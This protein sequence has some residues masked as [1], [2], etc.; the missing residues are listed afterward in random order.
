MIVLGTLALEVFTRTFIFENSLDWE[1]QFLG[2]FIYLGRSESAIVVQW[3]L[4]LTNS[5]V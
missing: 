5:S 1:S 3:N 4:Y 2:D